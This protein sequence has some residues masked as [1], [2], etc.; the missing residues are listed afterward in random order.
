MKAP[1]H[2]RHAAVVST[3][4]RVTTKILYTLSAYTSHGK[5]R[6]V[7]ARIASAADL[8]LALLQKAR[9]DDLQDD[10]SI[11]RTRT[12]VLRRR[13]PVLAPA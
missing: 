3:R 1:G 10:G 4:S 2:S 11:G 8:N 5:R 6:P 12:I 9:S 7:A 13:P